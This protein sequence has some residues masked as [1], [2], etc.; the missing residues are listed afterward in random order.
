MTG[1]RVPLPSPEAVAMRSLSLSPELRLRTLPGT[2][3]AFNGHKG[4]DIDHGRIAVADEVDA[5][6][7]NPP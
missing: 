3:A 6:L 1:L 5:A 7:L 2:G 4:N